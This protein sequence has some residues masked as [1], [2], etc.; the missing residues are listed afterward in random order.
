MI[1]F[2]SDISVESLISKMWRTSEK[3]RKRTTCDLH[4][5][6]LARAEFDT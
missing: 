4:R 3:G 6:D 2:Y 1:Q 5:L